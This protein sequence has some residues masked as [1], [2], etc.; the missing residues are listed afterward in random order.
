MNRPVG[1]LGGT[2]DPIHLGHLRPALEVLE[3]LQLAEIRLVPCHIPPHRRRPQASAADRVR[4]LE[5]AVD[6]QAGF[7]V[8]RRELERAG[9]SYS[10]DTL[11]S[12]RA[13]LGPERPLCLIMGMDAFAGLPSW[14]RWERLIELAHIVVTHRPGSP[15]S[16]DIDLGEWLAQVR[17]EDP[18]ALHST[19]S[20]HVWFCP[21]TQLDISATD[22][23]RRIAAGRSPRYLTPEAVWAYI[24]DQGLYRQRL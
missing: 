19:P 20:G 1:V 22:I 24:R 6:G 17:T 15:A 8:D 10:V 3:Q 12:L 13:E 16:Q 21:V 14:H 4:M 18:K 11:S 2:F 23:R 7:T 5:L 9:P